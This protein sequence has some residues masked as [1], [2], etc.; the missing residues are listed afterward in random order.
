MIKILLTPI[1]LCFCLCS[2]A[3][4]PPAPPGPALNS[5]W[6]MSDGDKVYPTNSA[7]TP[8]QIAVLRD[9]QTALS[10][11]A[12]AT[13]SISTGAVYRANEAMG[14]ITFANQDDIVVSQVFVTSVGTP[15]AASS[16]QI[17]KILGFVPTGSPVTN[18]RVIAEFDQLQTTRPGL[19]WRS[20]LSTGGASGSEWAASI[21]TVSSW[22]TSIS[23]PLA[24]SP[25]VYSFDQPVLGASAS[26]FVRV[27]SNDSGGAGSGFYFVI[28]NGLI[29]NGRMGAT[30][31]IVND[32]GGTNTFVSGLLVGT[33]EGSL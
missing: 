33:L 20:T 18:V 23:H 10:A 9:A 13:Y 21:N 12:D 28:Y 30:R 11:N 8:S 17:I 14:V 22:P 24:T 19:D 31:I 7:A 25:F 15:A 27:V 32:L 2:I 29:I 3:Q 26:L 1:V 4:D 5:A 6:M 16:N